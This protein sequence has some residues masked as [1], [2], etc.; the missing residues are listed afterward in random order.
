MSL[1]TALPTRR[2][3]DWK[4]LDLKPLAERDWQPAHPAE[5]D[6][7][8]MILP[9]ARGSR[10]AFINGHFDPH[11]SA[12]A[13][14]ST[15][16]FEASP[17]D[18]KAD[19]SPDPF[20]QLNLDHG[21][22][23][24]VIQ[25]P[26]ATKVDVP[27]HVLFAATGEGATFPRLK[28]VLEEGA[29]AELIEEYRS[30][31]PSLALPRVEIHLAAGATLRHERIQRESAEAFHLGSLRA[32]LQRDAR[33]HSRTLTF[34]AR[35]SRQAPEVVL[36][37]PGAEATLDGLALLAAD[38]VADTHSFTRHSAPHCTSRQLHKVIVDGESQAIFNGRVHVAP[39][40]VGTDGR[41]QCRAL[42][43]SGKATV[44]AKPQ[45]EI[46]ADD[47]K[48][49]HGAAIGQL[50]PEAVFYLQSR[51]LDET[52]AR[53]LLT[54]GFAADLLAHLP[55]DSLRRKLRKLVMDRTQAKEGGL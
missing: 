48:C 47:V 27:L 23:G 38:Q 9:E 53:N 12:S 45:L 51:G 55:V 50:D 34:G 13:L 31:G 20:H 54:Y 7:K 49:S 16:R 32:T 22:A 5:L 3:E 18:F 15:L 29:E 52:A 41:Q 37:E 25:I 46:H 33:Y 30:E 21:S 26:K 24:A 43:L 10:L 19:G 35:L 11:H 42:L 40:A 8:D 44:D 1:L 2:Q 14:P 36:A 6:L 4:Y 39:H 17:I 28:V